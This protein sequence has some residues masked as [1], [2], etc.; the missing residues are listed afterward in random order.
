LGSRVHGW[1]GTETPA[2]RIAQHLIALVHTIAG[3]KWTAAILTGVDDGASP[4]LL[5]T[6][7]HWVACRSRVFQQDSRG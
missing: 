5:P 7:V 2:G 1:L 3:I 4:P 6:A